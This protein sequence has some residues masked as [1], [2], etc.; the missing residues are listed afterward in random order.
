MQQKLI[1]IAIDGPVSAGKSTLSD[2][3]A[4]KLNI[5]HL[6]T[7]AMY[8]AVGLCALKKG[9]SPEDEQAVVDMCLQGNAQVDVRYNNQKQQTMLNGQDV[10]QDIR[11]EEVGLAAST[12]SRY[13][14]VRSYLVERQQ[15][16]ASETSI[17]M[18]GRDIGTVVLPHA[19]VKI[20]LTASPE[21]RAKRRFEQL[22]RQGK[23]PDF[24]KVLKDLKARDE[25]D[26]NRAA[27]PLRQ[28]Q[29]AVLLDTSDLD[30]C[31]SVQAILDVVE[32]KYGKA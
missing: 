9:I 24:D 23:T 27:D 15:A 26:M 4:K 1:S 30:F 18:D 7:G 12:V 25:Q 16:I 29:D 5:L 8:R 14:K 11:T 19:P 17:L 28:A 20:F 10:S 22:Q 31:D 13:P 21:A 6:D 2:A 32:A 3:V